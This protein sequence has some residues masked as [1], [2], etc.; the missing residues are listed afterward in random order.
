M[1]DAATPFAGWF[2]GP[3]ALVTGGASG[4]GRSIAN[5]FATAAARV[6]VAD[7]S[8]DGGEETATAIKQ[9]GSEAI[10]VRIDVSQAMDVEAAV[11]SAVSTYGGLD[12]AVNAA[13][14]KGE[15]GLLADT[16]ED[17]FDRLIAVNLKSIFLSM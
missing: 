4:M 11:A 16:D 17:I 1:T 13:A 8:V 5:A 7:V 15:S 10:F 14:I 9:A 3:V 12:A 2:D 6:V